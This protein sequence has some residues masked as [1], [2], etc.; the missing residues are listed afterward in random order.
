MTVWV[1]EESDK[2]RV[3]RSDEVGRLCSQRECRIPAVA[4]LLRKNFRITCGYYTRRWFCCALPEH[5]YGHKV[6]MGRVWKKDRSLN[7][8]C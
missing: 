4:V 2:W 1:P 8:S 6:E 3:I 7:S 5:L